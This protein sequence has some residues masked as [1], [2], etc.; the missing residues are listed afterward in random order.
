MEIKKYFLPIFSL[1][2]FFSCEINEEP[3][4]DADNLLLGNWT[5]A[6]YNFDEE[7]TTFSRVANMPEEKYAIS[8][9]AD[10]S[11][12][13]RTSGWCGTPPLSFFN[14]DGSFSLQE[15]II[16]INV[17]SYPSS[18]SWRIIKLTDT[19]LVVKRELTAQEI[20]HQKLMKLYDEI[21]TLAYNQNC[22]NSNDWSFTAYGS[23]ACGGPQGFIPYS[24]KIDAAAFLKKVEEYTKAEDTFN[25]NWGIISTCDLPAQPKSV[26]CKNGYPALKYE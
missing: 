16:T 12:L 23:K 8:L 15:N 6:T 9:K 7:S 24:T 5:N 11:F 20:D 18:Y 3:T 2:L 26:E 13:E 21:F 10:N 1:I 22:T 25:K 14:V 4:I 17:N 19:E